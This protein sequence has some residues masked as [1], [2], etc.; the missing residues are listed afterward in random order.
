MN[1]A[2][3]HFALRDLRSHMTSSVRLFA[4]LGVSVVLTLLAP[5]D[6]DEMLKPLPRFFYWAVLSFAG[7]SIGYVGNVLAD[8]LAP[9]KG[10]WVRT[11]IA[12]PLTAIGVFALVLMLDY[13]FMGYTP[14]LDSALF[15]GLNVLAI[16]FVV[17]A[18]MQFAYHELHNQQ[19]AQEGTHPTLL[20]RMPFDKRGPLVSISSEDHYIRVCTT[21]GEELVLMRLVDAIREVGATKGLQVHRS[22]WVALDQ[23]SAVDK[24]KD[25]ATLG[26]AHGQDIPV[27]RSYL[28]ALR[29]VG[30]L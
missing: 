21:K 7:Y 12:A 10:P 26:M 25:K 19:T 13:G 1:T 28:S 5:F 4:L 11:L 22:H 2:N 14:N 15:S 3:S 17:S 9:N 16:S 18:I 30:V 24:K 23:I 8:R 20:D 6:T 27:S 29:D